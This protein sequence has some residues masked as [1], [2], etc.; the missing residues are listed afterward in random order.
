M[1]ISGL[2][3]QRNWSTFDVAEEGV[4]PTLFIEIVEPETCENDVERKVGHYA[5]AWVA[6][7]VIVDNVGR[8]GQ[9]QLQL[10]NYRLLGD[11]Y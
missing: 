4:R 2:R 3:E 9:R 5:R 11:R 10:L 7:Y 6:Q 1:V 8:Q